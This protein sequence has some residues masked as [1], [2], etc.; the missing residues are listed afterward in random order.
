MRV[1]L[2]VPSTRIDFGGPFGKALAL[3]SSLQALGVEVMVMGGGLGVDGT[4]VVGL[5]SLTNF[6]GTPIPRQYRPLLR[7]IERAQVL[8]VLGFRDP[9]GTLAMIKASM[10]SV[11]RILE[12]CGMHRRRLRSETL[13]TI[14]DRSLGNHLVSRSARLI[15]TSSL[16]SKEL[17]ADGVE[18]EMIT[19][20]PNG[21][22]ADS[23]TPVHRKEEF[24][25]QMDIFSKLPLVL[26]LGRITRKKSLEHL[27][28][29]LTRAPDLGALIVGPDSHDGTLARLQ[30]M[31]TN[32]GLEDRVFIRARGVWGD[33]KALALASSDLFCLPSET[34]NFGTAAA[35]A[36]GAG[37]PVIVSD[38]CGV[39]EYLPRD[40][41][42]VI[43]F[44]DIDGLAIA[45]S[46]MS[47]PRAKMLAEAGSKQVQEDLDWDVLAKAQLE[48]YQD[49]LRK[50][51]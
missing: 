40:S 43:R 15:A 23:S 35:E 34:E 41:T 6:H 20:R 32:L 1:L 51:F 3:S 10:S 27:L 9:V 47:G 8:H 7:E 17:Q 16:E 39:A 26:S 49:V 18:E 14:F 12:P 11:P 4:V 13:K 50:T 36:A 37:L 22:D 42:R 48:I 31:R 38:R 46:D 25:E 5:G 30:E 24:R 33:E 21:I 2:T 29:A 45:L 28:L 19:V 44:G